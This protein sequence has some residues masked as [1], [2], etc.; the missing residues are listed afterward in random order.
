MTRS[1]IIKSAIRAAKIEIERKSKWA[2]EAAV[3]LVKLQAEL[4]ALEAAK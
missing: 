3:E 2:A 1:Q 4:R